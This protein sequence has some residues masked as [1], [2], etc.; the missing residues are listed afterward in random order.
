YAQ[1]SI[2]LADG[3]TQK[4]KFIVYGVT[5]PKN[6]ENPEVAMAFVKMLLSEKGQKIMDDSGQPP[7]DPPLT[8]DAD[9]LPLELEDLVEIEG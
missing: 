4:G 5:I 9:T 7:Y 6:S 8:K 1:A 2:T 3:K